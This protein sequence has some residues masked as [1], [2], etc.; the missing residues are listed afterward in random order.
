MLISHVQLP[1]S[2]ANPSSATL[3]T[4][5]A[6]TVARSLSGMSFSTPDAMHLRSSF[7]CSR[8]LSPLAIRIRSQSAPVRRISSAASQ[9]KT[10]AADWAVYAPVSMAENR[11][12][13]AFTARTDAKERT[14]ASATMAAT[15]QWLPSSL[16]M[17]RNLL[18][19]VANS[20]IAHPSFTSGMSCRSC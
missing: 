12:P 10:S 13:S 3:R 17:A 19:T 18:A 4:S 11:S 2:A 14:K 1:S 15:H 16:S 8:P 7:L 9:S 6:A 20:F 5:L